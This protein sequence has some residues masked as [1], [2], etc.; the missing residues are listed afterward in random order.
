MARGQHRPQGEKF[1]ENNTSPLPYAIP[2][3]HLCQPLL[4][5]CIPLYWGQC[6]LLICVYIEDNIKQR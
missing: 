3:A 6:S 5:F 1:R 2:N 4:V